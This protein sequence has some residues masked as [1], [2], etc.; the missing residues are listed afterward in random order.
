MLVSCSITKRRGPAQIRDSRWFVSHRRPQKSRRDA[1]FIEPG[2]ERP[3]SSGGATRHWRRWG[4]RAIWQVVAGT[5][6]AAPPGLPERHFLPVQRTKP[7]IRNGQTPPEFSFRNAGLPIPANISRNPC[8]VQIGAPTSAVTMQKRFHARAAKPAKKQAAEV[9]RGHSFTHC[10][11]SYCSAR[12]A[13]RLGVLGVL[14]VRRPGFF[15]IVT[16]SVPTLPP[17]VIVV[18]HSHSIVPGGLLVRSKTTR[19]TPRT[20]LVMRVEIFS[21]KS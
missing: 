17:G 2:F 11:V 18:H 1:L 14:G 5:H 16:A 21:S 8:K 13:L 6:R 7:Q 3:T 4:T 12:I 10:L 19:F 20:S 9:T 15:C